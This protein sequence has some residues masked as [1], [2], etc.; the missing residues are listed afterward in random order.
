MRLECVLTSEDIDEKRKEIGVHLNA[1]MAADKE[2]QRLQDRI[3][4]IKAQQKETTGKIGQLQSEI[5][6]EKEFREVDTRE[7][8]EGGF[9]VT[10]RKDTGEQ[11][12]KRR[13]SPSERS[14]QKE[15]QDKGKVSKSEESKPEKEEKPKTRQAKTSKKTAKK[16]SNK[17]STR[18]DAWAQADEKAGEEDE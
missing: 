13:L 14:A 10:Y 6:E 8:I 1:N 7:E 17:R 9:M 5:N 3:K 11:V 2:I 12:H 4:S 16:A 18:K 15:E